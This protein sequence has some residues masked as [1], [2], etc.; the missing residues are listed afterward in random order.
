MVDGFIELIR[1]Y[2]LTD[3]KGHGNRYTLLMR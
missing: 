1:K 3:E 2:I